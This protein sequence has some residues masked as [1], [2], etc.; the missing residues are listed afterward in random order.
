MYEPLVRYVETGDVK[1]LEEAADLALRSGMF[2]EHVLDMALSLPPH[3]LPQKARRL[4]AGV[5]HV[6]ESTRCEDL[7][8]R[9]RVSCHVAKRRV[10]VLDIPAEAVPEVERLG[11]ERVVYAF[12]KASGVIIPFDA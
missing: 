8:E 9:L 10:S 6:V 3:L 2:L 5:R 1:Y 12:C 7:P 4:V 11:A